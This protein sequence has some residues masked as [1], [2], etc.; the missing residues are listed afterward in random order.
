MIYLLLAILGSGVIPVIFRAFDGWRVNLFW[1]ILVNYITCVLIGNLL[2]A[3]GLNLSSLVSQPWIGLAALQGTLLAVNFYLLAHTAQ[4]AGVAIAALASRLSVAIPSILAFAL[5]GDSLTT[6]KIAGLLAALLALYLCTAP[7]RNSA[8][9]SSRLF[10]LLPVLVFASFGVYFT[11]LKYLQTYY[12]NAS[13]YHSYVMSGFVFAL[14]SSLAIGLSK[15]VIVAAEFRVLHVIAGL[16]LG[17]INYVAV[18]SLLQVLALKGW[19]SSQLY[20][21]YSVGVVAVSTLLAFVAFR[22]KLSR[23]KAL[24]LAV[25]IV[26]V[27]LLNR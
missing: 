16:G 18:Y 9:L 26:A 15:R 20:P 1:A 13:S 24:G 25:G 23:R 6:I 3:D 7:D 21:I 2:A 12:L 17:L 4:R 22:E 8:G 5:Y 19:Q 11:I 27:A 10:H 14:L